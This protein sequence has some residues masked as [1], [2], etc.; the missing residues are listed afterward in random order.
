MC[1]QAAAA[2]NLAK[3]RFL[4]VLSHELRTPLTPVFLLLDALE[5]DDLS[6]KTLREDCALIRQSLQLELDLIDDLLDVS[7]IKSGKI[8]LN[9][10]AVSLHQLLANLHKL[11]QSLIDEKHLDIQFELNATDNTVM[12]DATRLQQVRVHPHLSA[13]VRVW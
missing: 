8:A 11:L 12:G 4:A 5:R 2:A 6:V 13:C 3:D 1:F 10:R 9:R 7:R